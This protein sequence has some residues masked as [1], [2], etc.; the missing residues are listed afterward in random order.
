MKRWDFV[1]GIW[2]RI[3]RFWFGLVAAFPFLCRVPVIAG[4]VDSNGHSEG[5]PAQGSYLLLENGGSPGSP[6]TMEEI[7]EVTDIAGGGGTTERI[8]KT[9]LRSPGNVREFMPSFQDP[10]Q[11]TFTIQYIPDNAVHQRILAL[12]K[13]GET[14]ALREVFPDANGWDYVGYIAGAVKGGQ[15]VGG[16]ITIAVT[17][18]MSGVTEFSGV[19]SPA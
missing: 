17:F 14:V 1:G 3:G 15:T 10:G 5:M 11:L 18:Q 7:P 2:C 12:Y 9:H 19:G 6:L 4:G 13:S 8:D 16:K